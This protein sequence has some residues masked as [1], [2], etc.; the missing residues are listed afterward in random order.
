MSKIQINLN[1]EALIFSIRIVLF[2]ASARYFYIDTMVRNPVCRYCCYPSFILS[3]IHFG[4]SVSHTEYENVAFERTPLSFSQRNV[5]LQSN[6]GSYLNMKKTSRC[7]LS[8]SLSYSTMRCM[9]VQGG[10]IFNLDYDLAPQIIGIFSS[11]N[12]SNGFYLFIH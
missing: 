6:H 10:R 12:D 5:D 11:M 8:R 1:I 7:K 9:H 4:L 3:L 2:S